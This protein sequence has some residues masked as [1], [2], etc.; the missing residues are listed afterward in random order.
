MGGFRGLERCIPTILRQVGCMLSDIDQRLCLYLSGRKSDL[1]SILRFSRI[2]GVTEG[3]DKVY[4]LSLLSR[5]FDLHGQEVF[6]PGCYLD[7]LLV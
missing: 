2:R 6:V 4:G 5:D 1:I 3:R 7:S